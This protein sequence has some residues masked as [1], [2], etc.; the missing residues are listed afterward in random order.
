M[1]QFW[2]S[3]GAVVELGS[4]CCIVVDQLSS[5]GGAVVEQF[6][7]GYVIISTLTTLTYWYRCDS[8]MSPRIINGFESKG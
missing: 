6:L 4:S 3:Y 2:S 8:E 1:E 5:S 7:S